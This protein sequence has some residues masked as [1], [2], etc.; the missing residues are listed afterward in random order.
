MP[1]PEPVS[2]SSEP[3]STQAR[4][5]LFPKTLWSE[6]RAAARADDAASFQAISQLCERYRRPLLVYLQ[7]HTKRD[8]AEDLLQGFLVK[9]SD[10]KFYASL[11]PEKGKFRSFLLVCLRNFLRDELGRQSAQR[12]GGGHVPASLDEVSDS[13]QPLLQ[14][15]VDEPSPDLEFD[16]AWARTILHRAFNKLESEQRRAGKD[17]L[18]REAKS[19]LLGTAVPESGEIIA[20]RHSLS[21]VHFRVTL[22]R[23][24]ARLGELVIEQ[25]QPT[26]A[27]AEDLQSE[28]HYLSALFGMKGVEDQ[29]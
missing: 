23:L 2:S 10:R 17:A 25:I 3:A 1:E 5:G 29:S 26:V 24:K 27:S 11:A 8:E 15:V 7:H 20:R 14:P 9:L 13:G 12:R 6:V 22:H 18:F 16:R 19:L 4:T 28:L 21:P